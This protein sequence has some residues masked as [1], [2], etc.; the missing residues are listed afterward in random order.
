VDTDNHQ[1]WRADRAEAIPH[2]PGDRLPVRAM[3]DPWGEFTRL[4][5]RSAAAGVPGGQNGVQVA[6]VRCVVEIWAARQH[7][8]FPCLSAATN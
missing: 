3:G 4:C 2:V 1:R 6:L 5:R 7:G 8:R